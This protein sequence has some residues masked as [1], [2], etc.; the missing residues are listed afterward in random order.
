M[1]CKQFKLVLIFAVLL[2]GFSG[3]SQTIVNKEEMP[4]RSNIKEY[5]QYY[6]EHIPENLGWV[7]DFEN[8][9]S[10]EQIDTL[11]SIVDKYEKLT[12][13]EIAIVTLDSSVCE[14]K[15]FFNLTLRIAQHWG[16]GKAKLNNGVL[17]GLST[18]HRTIR[19]QNGYGIE[20]LITDPETKSI[21][22]NYFIPRYKEGAYYKGTRDGVE[23]LINLLNSKLKA[24]SKK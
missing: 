18:G 24:G 20:K 11:T 12:G 14:K 6:W 7:S 8:V 5:R 21:I 17:I 19:I 9:F 23:G 22:E 16:V 15:D 10:K 1:M 3:C 4:D 2:F 13:I